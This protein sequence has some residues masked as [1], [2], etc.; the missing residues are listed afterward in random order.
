MACGGMIRENI[1]SFCFI[2]FNFFMLILIHRS[3]RQSE[4]SALQSDTSSLVCLRVEY[5]SSDSY[6][7]RDDFVFF[8]FHGSN[9]FSLFDF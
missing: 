5:Y 4:N 6:V 3:R 7:D 2:T 1:F 9:F 8:F